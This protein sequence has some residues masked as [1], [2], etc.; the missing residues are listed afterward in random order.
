M[1]TRYLSQT[2]KALPIPEPP[3]FDTSAQQRDHDKHMLAAAVRLFGHL[4]FDDGISG[5]LSIRDPSHTDRFWVNPF[6]VAFSR[7]QLDDLICVDAEGSIVHGEHPVNPSAYA[8]HSQVLHQRPDAQAAIH[9]HSANSRAFGALNV[10]LEPLDQESAAFHENHA[11]FDDYAGP[12]TEP[13]QGE[14]MARALATNR[15]VLLRFHG[16]ITVGASIEE[17]AYW[18]ISFERCAG[19]QLAAR[20]AG[21]IHPMTPEQAASAHTGFGDPRLAWFNFRV[22]L[23]QTAA[24]DATFQAD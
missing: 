13:S 4:G 8:I 9:C 18:F 7:V 11:I 3:V 22:L 15:A 14:A 17:A 24:K 23:Q 1:T 20:A 16:L 2:D 12:T 19:Q 10:P 5:H 21:P 6:G